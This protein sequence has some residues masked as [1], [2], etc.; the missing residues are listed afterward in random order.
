MA[1]A[2]GGSIADNSGPSGANHMFMV[3]DW[4]QDQQQLM[5]MASGAGP[6]HRRGARV[7]RRKIWCRSGPGSGAVEK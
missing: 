3:Q 2:L 6:R 7:C 4:L 1:L 5:P